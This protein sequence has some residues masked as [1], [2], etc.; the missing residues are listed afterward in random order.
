MDLHLRV[1]VRGTWL[2]ASGPGS[3][4]SGQAKPVSF[5]AL[6]QG[7]CIVRWI[8]WGGCLALI[9]IP[10]G[11]RLPDGRMPATASPATGQ[12]EPSV[13]RLELPPQAEDVSPSP[14]AAGGQ[15][16]LDHGTIQVIEGSG[17]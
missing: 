16:E 5:L 7:R 17:R 1:L 9:A 15:E 6:P 11:G 14:L 4:P 8:I 10:L 13:G 2:C 12:V 3:S